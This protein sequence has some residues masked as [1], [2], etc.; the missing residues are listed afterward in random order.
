[1]TERLNIENARENLGELIG[2]AATALQSK[3]GE[4]MVV[5]DVRGQSSVTDFHLLATG[6][7]MPQLKALASETARALKTARRAPARASGT[8][9]SGWE[10]IDAGDLIV[11]IFD[12]EHR[13]YYRLE[14]LWNDADIFEIES[15]EIENEL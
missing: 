1:M 4:N 15:G 7:N 14:E 12:R 10:I 6:R 5:L 13:D 8:P 9:D 3:K 11:H 2:V